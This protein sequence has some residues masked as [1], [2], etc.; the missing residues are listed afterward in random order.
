MD[1]RTIVGSGAYT[2]EVDKRWG[3]RDGAIPAFGLVSGVACDSRDRVYQFIRLPNP[4]VSVFDR[5][6]KL[7]HEWGQGQFK[8]PH[9]IWINGRDELYLTDRDTHLVTQWTADG[10]LLRSWGTPDRPGAPGAP[11]NQ[12][13][14]AVV[15]SDGE[16]YVSDGYGQHRVHRFAADGSLLTSWG[17]KGTGPGQFALPHDVWV[18]PRNR[19]MV[20]D[21]ENQRIQFFDR[22]GAFTGEWT[23]LKAP[24][25]VYIKDDIIY[26]AEAGQQISIMT[27]DRTLLARW[28]SKGP[29]PDQFTDSP[30]SIW[31][32]SRGDIYVSEVIAQDKFQ[33]YVRQ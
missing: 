29:A 31:V 8:H 9:G 4:R 13:T 17:E 16:L 30:H 20:C 25:Q 5:N 10:K 11:F 24:M 6:G 19:V 18:D 14:H 28:G 23:D 15:T 27:L 32:D 3:R 26:L 2:Y 1:Q 21:R 12:P 33:K 7:L 22:K